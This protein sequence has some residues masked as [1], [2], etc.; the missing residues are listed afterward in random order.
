MHDA[1]L[2]R[3]LEGLRDLF[4]NAQRVD[5]RYRSLRDP[6]GERLPFDQLEH[7]RVYGSAV[8]ETV[9]MAM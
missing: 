2:V 6:I 4:G 1:V 7:E 3:D 5:D 8:F 9:D